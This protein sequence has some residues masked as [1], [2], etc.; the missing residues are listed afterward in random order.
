MRAANRDE[1]LSLLLQS[2]TLDVLEGE[3]RVVV[4]AGEGAF[5]ELILYK[6]LG[7]FTREAVV[8]YA[9]AFCI[10]R[11]V[12]LCVVE[13]PYGLRQLVVVAK[14]A[15]YRYTFAIEVGYRECLGAYGELAAALYAVDEAS[16]YGL[17]R[18]GQRL[19]EQQ[20]ERCNLVEVEVIDRSPNLDGCLLAEDSLTGRRCARR[21]A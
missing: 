20:V 7:R 12:G 4:V 16:A 9:V 17:Q 5:A 10:G 2:D 11:D 14:C 18:C 3:L 8:D 13:I 15:A 19:Y 21:S 1:D 6:R